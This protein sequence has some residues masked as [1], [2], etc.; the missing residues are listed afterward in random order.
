MI[1]LVCTN[2]FDLTLKKKKKKKN[3]FDLFYLYYFY[4]G[5][6]KESLC[7]CVWLFFFFF[8]F[9]LILSNSSDTTCATTRPCG[10]LWFWGSV[11]IWIHH[12]PSTHH[13]SPHGRVVTQVVAQTFSNIASKM[14]EVWI[15]ETL[16]LSFYNNNNNN[17]NNKDNIILN[18]FWKWFWIFKYVNVNILMIIIT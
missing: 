7:G 14:F 1:V 15:D 6:I 3:Y 5:W 9:L 16:S 4:V 2:C 17:N 13:N 10:E 18:F 8:F 12:H 11:P